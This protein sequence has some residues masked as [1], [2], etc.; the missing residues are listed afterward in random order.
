[1]PN[2]NSGVAFGLRLLRVADGLGGVG[3]Q[4][5][6]RHGQAVD[7]Q[8]QVHGLIGGRVE[9][10]L[11]HHA[12]AH[13]LVGGDGG[14]V[15]SGGRPRL[16]HA[17]GGGGADLEA[18]AEHVERAADAGVQRLVQ[19]VDQAGDQL[20]PLRLLGRGGGVGLDNAPVVLG[21]VLGKPGVD[22]LGEDRVLAVVA[23]IVGRI[24]PAVLLQ[25]LA[26]VGLELA[27]VVDGHVR[28]VLR[29]DLDLAGDGGGDQ[30]GTT[31]LGELDEPLRLH[32]E[33]VDLRG[34]T[35]HYLDDSSHVILV[36]RP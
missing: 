26:D 18:L 8:H 1:M 16:G 27:L 3:L 6:R 25:V 20:V 22:V 32:D 15:V 13:S 2:P 30:R 17:E 34:L 31:L 5:D 11:T 33:G 4:L 35:G 19:H 23:G 36:L 14:R 21:L 12:E 9:V 10:H 29:G 28:S 7:E 24:E